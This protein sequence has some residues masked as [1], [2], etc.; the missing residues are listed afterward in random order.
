MASTTFAT[1]VGLANLPAL[2]RELIMNSFVTPDP[3]FARIPFVEAPA[4]SW[5]QKVSADRAARLLRL[6]TMRGATPR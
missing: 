3:M 6:F 4:L 5:R 2:L 1:S